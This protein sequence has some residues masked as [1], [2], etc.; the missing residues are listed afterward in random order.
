MQKYMTIMACFIKRHI[1]FFKQ[2]QRQ[3]E[4]KFLNVIKYLIYNYYVCSLSLSRFFQIKEKKKLYSYQLIN[5]NEL[6]T[7]LPQ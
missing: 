2:E 1:F 3:K 5:F 7:E 4:D 6:K